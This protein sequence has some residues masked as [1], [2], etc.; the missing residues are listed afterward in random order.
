MSVDATSTKLSLRASIPSA[1]AFR[2]GTFVFLN[3]SHT[4]GQD[5]DWNYAGY[6]KLWTYNLTYFDFLQQEGLRSEEGLTLIHDFIEQ[7][8][9]VKDGLEPFPISLR[10]INWVKFL[11]RH[12]VKE[13]KIDDILYAQYGR[14]LDNIEYHLLGNHLLENGFSLL[15]G[16]YYFQDEKLYKKAKEILTAE[17]DE[18][19]LSDGAHFELSPMYHQIMLFRLLDCINL[20]QNNSWLKD[21]KLCELLTDKAALMSG[22]LNTITFE[23]GAIP[24][25]N[26]SANQIAPTTRELN[27]YAHNLQVAVKYQQLADCGYRKF[28]NG[29]Y[30]IVLDVGNIG[31][32]YIPGHA[33]S[34]IFNFEL[35]VDH[36]PLIVD[37][38][39]STYEANERRQ[40]ERSTRS[41]NT[42]EVA[43][44]NQSDVW[45]GFRVGKRAR[46]FDIK[47][48]NKY[49]EATH[50]GYKEKGVL[51]TRKFIFE[52]DHIVIKDMLKGAKSNT[53]VA[54]FHF[55]PK[56]H[57][58][59]KNNLIECDSMI[60]E[61]TG[62]NE[63][64]LEPYEYVVEF[65][66]RTKAVCAMI[67]FDKEL[68]TRMILQKI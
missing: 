51:H 46:V 3:R 45:G 31:P 64:L 18:Q 10:G 16:A 58:Q 66:K 42:V 49:I 53:C 24:L 5:I 39:I 47:E 15:F 6:G 56:V 65:N 30:E 37:T 17:L 63:I 2:D 60:F 12:D 33:H 41:H 19:I 26:D 36:K 50:D 43:G 14:L 4:F 25:L 67:L 40:M 48:N 20:F 57:V 22:W 44:E 32:D 11:T 23:N 29:H 27:E 8:E 38:G 59:Q 9:D 34:D 1:N 13:Q 52:A 68:E 62:A 61:F 28:K 7:I 54:F 55:H 21:K 35:Y